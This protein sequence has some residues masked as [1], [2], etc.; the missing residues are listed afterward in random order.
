MLVRICGHQVRWQKPIKIYSYFRI[1]LVAGAILC[2]GTNGMASEQDS[3]TGFSASSSTT[4]APCKIVK[5]KAATNHARQTQTTGPALSPAMALALALGVRTVPGPMV[6]SAPPIKKQ[7]SSFSFLG[8]QDLPLAKVED[9]AF[10]RCKASSLPVIAM[11][12]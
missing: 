11:R 2:V 5:S 8:R 7:N 12:K 1:L 9:C 6:H 10:A 4:S 3:M